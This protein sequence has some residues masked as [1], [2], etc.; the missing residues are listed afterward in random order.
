M[1]PPNTPLESTPTLKL[2]RGYQTEFRPG[3]DASDYSNPSAPGTEMREEKD[4]R[5]RAAMILGCWEQLS[6]HSHMYGEKSIPQT[7]LRFEKTMIGLEVESGEEEWEDER[8]GDDK[9]KERERKD[10][11]QK[12]MRRRA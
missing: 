11:K 10:E 2:K 4:Q 12:K 5:E 7:R 6:W 1:P 8:E 9:G 3:E